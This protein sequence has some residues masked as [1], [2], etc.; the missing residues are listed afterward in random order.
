MIP[1]VVVSG[2]LLFS[3][4]GAT[5]WQRF[6]R[7]RNIIWIPSQGPLVSL[8]PACVAALTDPTEMSKIGVRMGMAFRYV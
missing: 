4:L 5:T 2:I 7:L 1:T 3:W 8:P 6:R